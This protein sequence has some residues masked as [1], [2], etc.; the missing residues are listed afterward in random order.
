MAPATGFLP[1]RGA[2]R[3]PWPGAFWRLRRI[4]ERR[5]RPSRSGPTRA[6]RSTRPPRPRPR[7]GSSAGPYLGSRPLRTP[8]MVANSPNSPLYA[9]TGLRQRGQNR[10]AQPPKGS[11]QRP[12]QE[13]ARIHVMRA[14]QPLAPASAPR[15]RSFRSIPPVEP[16]HAAGPTPDR[17]CKQPLSDSAGGGRLFVDL[18]TDIN[19]V[20][21]QK[22]AVNC[23]ISL[24]TARPLN[25]P[26]FSSH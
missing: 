8:V 25:R 12:A 6:T 7:P 16:K 24:S 4:L 19:S 15:R 21:R 10:A 3:R 1:R 2:L 23:P 9:S 26:G 18:S 14:M 11:P 20:S 5:C 13:P 22:S 17:T